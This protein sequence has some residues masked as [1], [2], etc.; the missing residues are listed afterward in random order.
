MP[1][2]SPSAQP[3][4]HVLWSCSRSLLA[5]STVTSA[6][7]STEAPLQGCQTRLTSVKNLILWPSL[8]PRY[9]C[10]ISLPAVS[11]LPLWLFLL[12][13]LTDPQQCHSEASSHLSVHESSAKVFI[14]SLHSRFSTANCTLPADVGGTKRSGHHTKRLGANQQDRQISGLKDPKGD[15]KLK[16]ISRSTDSYPTPWRACPE[17]G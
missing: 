17:V 16:K 6:S 5:F 3:P 7:P 1:D 9:F 13:F 15:W 2:Y 11:F 4:T 10:G 8:S 14:H 12:P